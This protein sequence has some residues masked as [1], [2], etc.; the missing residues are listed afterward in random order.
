M[1]VRDS[2]FLILFGLLIRA[3]RPKSYI[4]RTLGWDQYPQGRWGDSRN[5]SYGALTDH[6]V[7]FLFFTNVSYI[8]ITA[9]VI[10]QLT[11]LFGNDYLLFPST[12]FRIFIMCSG[13]HSNNSL[14]PS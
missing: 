8:S 5:P 11:F 13:P 2:C 14:F 1:F 9:G 3:N 7:K 6:Q 12:S 4:A 10:C